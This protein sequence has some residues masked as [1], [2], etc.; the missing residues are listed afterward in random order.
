MQLI[1]ALAFFSLTT[2]LWITYTIGVV[3]SFIMIQHIYLDKPVRTADSQ[4]LAVVIVFAFS[5]WL[6]IIQA[7]SIELLIIAGST[8]LVKKLRN[9]LRLS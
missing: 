8:Q 7:L 2:W 6:F 9:K 1:I 4:D 5:S 3:V